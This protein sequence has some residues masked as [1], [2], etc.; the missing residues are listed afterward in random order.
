MVDPSGIVSFTNDRGYRIRLTS[1]R[2]VVKN[3]AFAVDGHAHDAPQTHADIQASLLSWIMPTAHAHPGHFEGGEVTGELQGRFVLDWLARN[4]TPQ[5]VGTAL[6][7]LGNYTSANFVLG[8]GNEADSL[9]PQ[10]PLLG[11]TAVISGVASKDGT[12]LR[13]QA[14]LDSAPG[15]EVLGI[16]FELQVSAQ[17]SAPLGFRLHTLGVIGDGS[18][19]DGVDFAGLTLDKDGVAQ[20]T[21]NHQN[22]TARQAYTRLRRRFQTH[23]Q[24]DIQ[25]TTMQELAKHAAKLLE[26]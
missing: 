3:I 11:H 12:A 5:K 8:R 14:L 20:I 21:A 13:F 4:P 10:D 2:V 9:D 24:F 19:F 16:P 17:T 23:D 15:R 1:A 25:A 26:P 7:L 18:L 22:S 6:L